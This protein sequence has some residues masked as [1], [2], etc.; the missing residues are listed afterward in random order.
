MIINLKRPSN[1]NTNLKKIKEFIHNGLKCPY[2]NKTIKSLQYADLDHIIPV[3]LGGEI[4]P[5]NKDNYQLLCQMCHSKKTRVDKAIIK[6]FRSLGL[7]DDGKCSVELYLDIEKIVETYKLLF[8]YYKEIENKNK[9][10][11]PILEPIGKPNPQL[12][13]AIK[14][15]REENNY[16]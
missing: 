5:F 15:F 10:S 13:E 9:I 11:S 6:L 12:L 14:R 3:Y 2:C 8:S 1:Y 7:I 4:Y 16:E